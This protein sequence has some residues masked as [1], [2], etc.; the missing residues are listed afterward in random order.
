MHTLT[1]APLQAQDQKVAGDLA[2]AGRLGSRAKCYNILAALWTL[3][4]LLLLLGLVVAAALHLSQLAKGSAAFSA[5]S[6]LTQTMTDRL[7]PDAGTPPYCKAWA[8]AHPDLRRPAP[9]WAP[10]ADPFRPTLPFPT[11]RLGLAPESTPSLSGVGRW[12]QP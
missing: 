4:P 7:G 2:A 10:G 9:A 8:L 5:S 6:S 3:V 1:L 12:G 11:D